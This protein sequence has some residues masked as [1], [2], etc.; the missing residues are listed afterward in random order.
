MAADAT[1]STLVPDVDYIPAAPA[2]ENT[3]PVYPQCL[4]NLGLPPQKVVMRILVD[5]QGQV[6]EVRGSAAPSEV[7]PAYRADFETAISE[8]VRDWQFSP[9]M[10]RA[11]VDST[12]LDS[13][14]RPLHKVLKSV[15]PAPSYFDIRFIFEVHEGRAVEESV[16]APNPRVQ[17]TR[18]SPSARGSPL[19]RHPVGGDK[20]A[21][22]LETSCIRRGDGG[23][24]A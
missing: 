11:Y 16:S 7:D 15:K 17:R 12:E 20:V 22:G 9:A 23:T 6:M 19:T 14:G 13:K 2:P 21:V 5:D 24:A 3:A 10:R 18:S 4:L 1:S 8:A